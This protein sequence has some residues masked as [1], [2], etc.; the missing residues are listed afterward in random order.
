MELQRIKFM[1]NSYLRIRLEKIQNNIFY[2]SSPTPDNPSRLT[3]QVNI[4]LPKRTQKY[5]YFRKQNLRGISDRI[6]WNIL[7]TWP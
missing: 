3:V 1:V 6:Y 7:I 4:Y 5:D 2:Y